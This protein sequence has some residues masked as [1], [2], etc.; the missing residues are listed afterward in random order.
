MKPRKFW[1]TLLV[2][3]LS[4]SLAAVALAACNTTRG[5]GEDVE[6]TGE[7]VQDAAQSAE[8]ELKD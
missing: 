6:A 8:D 7:A 2:R 4:V 3:V 1:E 5:V